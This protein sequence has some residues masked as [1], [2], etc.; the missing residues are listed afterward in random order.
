MFFKSFTAF[1]G[2]GE[3]CIGFT[4]YKLFETPDVTQ[5]FQTPGMAGQI[6]VGQFE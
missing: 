3:C 6:T 5:F 2:Y 1:R 4:S